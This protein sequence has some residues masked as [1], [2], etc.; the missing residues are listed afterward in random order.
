MRLTKKRKSILLDGVGSSFALQA[1][2]MCDTEELQKN[3]K[4][5]YGYSQK[6]VEE[7][8]DALVEYLRK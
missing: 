1:L 3:F 7:A 2:W 5:D 8:I 6:E 4:K